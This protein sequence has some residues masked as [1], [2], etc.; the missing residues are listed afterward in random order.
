MRHVVLGWVIFCFSTQAIAEKPWDKFWLS[1]GIHQGMSEDEFNQTASDNRFT[2]KPLPPD[3][4]TKIVKTAEKEYWLLFCDGRLT[5]ASWIID[6]NDELIKSLNERLNNQ[7]FKLTSYKAS[8][9]YNDASSEEQNQFTMRLENPEREYSVT[10]DIFSRNGQV[11]VEDTAF[12][13]TANCVRE[14]S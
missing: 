7:G 8:S 5:Y 12:D 1:H 3:S 9:H 6:T 11:T 10:Y 13:D 2:I 4:A 14:K